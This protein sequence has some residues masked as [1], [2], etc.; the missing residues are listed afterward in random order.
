MSEVKSPLPTVKEDSEISLSFK[1]ELM[2]G[3]LIEE[4]SREAPMR[5]K[6]GQ[7]EFLDKIEELL[8]GLEL[9]TTA[10]LT[11]SPDRAF[12]RSNPDNIHKMPRDSFSAELPPEKGLVIGFNTPTGQEIPGT[13]LEVN[14]ETV[15]VDFNHPLAD[16]D[17]RFTATIEAIHD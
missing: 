17:V 12:G 14:E 10:K 9:G 4:A 1:L 3:T 11:L 13:I 5:F 2:D 7:G 8:V 15:T 6:L 16:T